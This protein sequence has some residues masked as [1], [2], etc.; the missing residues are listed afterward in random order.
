MLG[1]NSLPERPEIMGLPT[2]T[3]TSW[4]RDEAVP[5]VVIETNAF[6]ALGQAEKVWVEEP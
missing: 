4:E 6:N 3:A 2:D 5:V 1:R